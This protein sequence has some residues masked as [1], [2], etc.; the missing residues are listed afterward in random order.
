MSVMQY[1]WPVIVVMPQWKDCLAS[2]VY[3]FLHPLGEH[4]TE[5]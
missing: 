2:N 4:D 3:Q 5:P 1:C